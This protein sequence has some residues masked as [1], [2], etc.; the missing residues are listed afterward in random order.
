MEIKNKKN[1]G[2]ITSSGKWKGQKKRRVKEQIRENERARSARN[3]EKVDNKKEKERK[4]K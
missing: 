4:A 2:K 1:K 3:G